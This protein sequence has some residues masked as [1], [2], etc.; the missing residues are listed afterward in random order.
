MA[1]CLEVPL[2]RAHARP[3]HHD[4]DHEALLL[5][6]YAATHDARLRDD[7]VGRHLPLVASI[8][9]RYRSHRVELDDV[10]Q[11]AAIGLLK[12]LDRYDASRGVAF[13]TYAVPVIVG[14]IQRYLRDF[15]WAVRPP[16]ALQERGASIASVELALTAQLGKSATVRD[17]ADYLE[18]SVEQVLDGLEASRAREASSLDRTSPGGDSTDTLADSIGDEDP[19]LDRIEQSI[20]A[21]LLVARLDERERHIVWLRFHADLNQ[22]EIAAIV[23]CSQMHVSR[24]LRGALAKLSVVPRES[25]EQATTDVAGY[26]LQ[27][28]LQS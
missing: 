17:I 19:Q 15:T 20:T 1:Q 14:E 5:S 25:S 23:G 3:A 16:R 6:R 27:S 12:A 28:L 22:R 21:D 4:R 26:C 11:V 2:R 24:L 7:L 18:L 10:A 9:Q 8:V 13:T